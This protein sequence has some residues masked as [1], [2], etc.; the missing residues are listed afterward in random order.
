MRRPTRAT[1]CESVRLSQAAGGGNGAGSA[2][3]EGR[4]RRRRRRRH[5]GVERD[6]REPRGRPAGRRDRERPRPD[7][8]QSPA[9]REVAL[10]VEA[11]A[12]LHTDRVE[13]QPG[14]D[15]NSDLARREGPTVMPGAGAPSHPFP[16]S[17]RPSSDGHVCAA[18]VAV[19]AAEAMRATN[20]TITK[21]PSRCSFRS[22]AHAPRRSDYRHALPRTRGPATTRTFAFVRTR[23]CVRPG[24]GIPRMSYR[25]LRMLDPI[26]KGSSSPG[27][28]R[29]ARRTIA[30]SSGPASLARGAPGRG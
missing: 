5:A 21:R 18:A 23:I 11:A 20:T 22:R 29:R 17:Q 28:S 16:T 3:G 4:R 19:S 1:L 14:R 6:V 13:R 24:E 2:G 30:A 10:D 25:V 7:N 9:Q 26:S 12:R 15:G 27:L 8:G